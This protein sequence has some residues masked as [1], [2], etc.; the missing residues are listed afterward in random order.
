MTWPYEES[1]LPFYDLLIRDDP[2]LDETIVA[3]EQ[4]IGPV[5]QLLTLSI[6]G[7]T[8]YG[9]AVGL[10]AQFLQV[11]GAVGEWLGRFPLLT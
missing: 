4:H 11:Q 7:V 5:Q 6:G 10:A 9:C 3:G 8:L 1:C 2:R